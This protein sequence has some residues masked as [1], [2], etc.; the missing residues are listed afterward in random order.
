MVSQNTVRTYGINRVFRFVEG[1]SYID[2]VVKSEVLFGKDRF[3]LIRAQHALT[4]ILY[5]YHGLSK[6]EKS[7]QKPSINTLYMFYIYIHIS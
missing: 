7:R 2:I 6:Q 5:K 3:Y 4:T 1:F